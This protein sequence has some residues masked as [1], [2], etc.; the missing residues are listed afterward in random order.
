VTPQGLSHMAKCIAREHKR[1]A[2][3]KQAEGPESEEEEDNLE[4][5][6]HSDG[7]ESDTRQSNTALTHAQPSKNTMRS[8]PQPKK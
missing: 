2:A 5:D 7:N 4:E 8:R 6:E 3:S 1:M